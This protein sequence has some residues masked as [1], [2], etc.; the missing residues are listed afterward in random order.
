MTGV[1][2][3][4]ALT[5]VTAVSHDPVIVAEVSAEWR[6]SS[7]SGANG[8]VEVRST[9]DGY[10]QLRQSQDPDDVLVFSAAEWAA[11]LAGAGAGEFDLTDPPRGT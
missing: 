2:R 6:K 7:A 5:Q 9:S 11:F 4:S 8:C 1:S 3:A 10:V